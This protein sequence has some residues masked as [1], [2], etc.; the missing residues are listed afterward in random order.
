ML[1]THLDIEIFADALAN[2]KVNRKFIDFLSEDTI[3]IVYGCKT[4]EHSN[5]LSDLLQGGGEAPKP[6]TKGHSFS[7]S[8]NKISTKYPYQIYFLNV[9][10]TELKA[11]Y[12]HNKA[13]LGGFIDDY[14]EVF[15]S[16]RKN[17]KML[18][19][20]NTE[21]DETAFNKWDDISV[22]LPIED[23]IINDNYFFD[24]KTET[25]IEEN[26][27][28]LID[29]LRKAGMKNVLIITSKNNSNYA[30]YIQ[31]LVSEI[32]IRFTGLT[33]S[34]VLYDTVYEKGRHLFTKYFHL[35]MDLSFNDLFDKFG[36]LRKN[37]S[38]NI[39]IEPYSSGK[40][41]SNAMKILRDI[42][43]I[44]DKIPDKNYV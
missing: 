7:T 21:D 35:H 14:F 3:L 32:S 28:A 4:I 38:Y 40:N 37:R 34:I 13:F 20:G 15:M 12:R 24:S 33:C 23:V 16:L 42:K 18:R 36:R 8:P 44:M 25:P 17:E 5:L 22:N 39:Y 31:E 2:E 43:F 41:C 1:K 11:K 29:V 10:N 6:L 19:G 27:Y 26:G 9:L 30:E